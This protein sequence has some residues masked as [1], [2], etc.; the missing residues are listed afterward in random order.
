M[1]I[2]NKCEKNQ[3]PP[4]RKTKCDECAKADEA[5]W[6]AK[7]TPI[8]QPEPVN[9]QVEK[10]PFGKPTQTQ[11]IK[12]ETGDFQSTV[13]NHSV[14]ANS[15]ELGKIGDRHKIYWETVEELVQKKMDLQSAGFLQGDSDEFKPE[16]V[17][18]NGYPRPD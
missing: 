9:P 5:Q 10:V 7:G 6:A 4:Y 1:T 2:C 11:G 12:A 18:H 17:P 8:A 13:W 3:V 16:H 14:A 15:S